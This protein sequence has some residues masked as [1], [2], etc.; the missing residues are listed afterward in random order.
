MRF[1][2]TAQ[3]C[4]VDANATDK[5]FD[6]QL[7][8]AY[9]KYNEEMTR[10]GVLIAAEG[11]RPNGVHVRVGCTGGKPVVLDGP[12]TEAKELIGGFYLIEVQSR[13]EAVQWALRHP[14]VQSGDETLEL[15]QLTEL[16]DLPPPVRQLIADGAP[17]WSAPLWR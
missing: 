8:L 11:V 9:M 7:F 2:I 16:A 3:P 6:E 15:R 13:D 12:F 17:E 14:A 10:A 1:L 4:K 5:P